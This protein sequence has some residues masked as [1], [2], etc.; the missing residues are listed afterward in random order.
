MLVL[1]G[2]GMALVQT[3]AAA[4][5]TS[6]PAGRYG[7]AV[8]LYSMV[9]F[10]GSAVAAAWV[11]LAYP[12]G[13]MVAIFLACSLLAALALAASYLGRDPVPTMTSTGV[14]RSTGRD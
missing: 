14:S 7:A 1:L 8:G 10:S 11:A 6:S 9:R 2:F 3:P 4:G 13:S 12:T 5:A